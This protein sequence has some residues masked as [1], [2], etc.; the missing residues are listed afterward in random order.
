LTRPNKRLNVE[1]SVYD[2]THETLFHL[3][4]KF[5]LFQIIREIH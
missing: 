4:L 1:K 3:E 5:R 2:P